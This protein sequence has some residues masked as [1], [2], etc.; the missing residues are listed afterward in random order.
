MTLFFSCQHYSVEAQEWLLGLYLSD[1]VNENDQFLV[2]CDVKTNGEIF[3]LV[4]TF[5]VHT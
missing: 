4:Y 3:T 5:S 2:S 1:L